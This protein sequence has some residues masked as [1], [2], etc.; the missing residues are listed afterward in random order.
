[1]MAA[2]LCP[3]VAFPQHVR[4]AHLWLGLTL[5]ATSDSRY[6][7]RV[8]SPNTLA[9]GGGGRAST[10]YPP[11]APG[12]E[13]RPY[14]DMAREQHWQDTDEAWDRLIDRHPDLGHSAPRA[15]RASEPVLRPIAWLRQPEQFKAPPPSPPLNIFD[16]TC[17]VVP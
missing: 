14:E 6:L 11:R 1:M 17:V 15:A 10:G 5:T 12:P 2:L 16:D 3:C 9:L 8:P 7:P 4:V 13:K